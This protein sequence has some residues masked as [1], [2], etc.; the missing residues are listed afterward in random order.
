VPGVAA[1]G[2]RLGMRREHLADGVAGQQRRFTGVERRGAGVEH[3]V[4]A[5]VEFAS[6]DHV[7]QRRMVVPIGG[8]DLELHLVARRHCAVA[9]VVADEQH[10]LAASH[11][12]PA[13][14][15]IAVTAHDRIDHLAVDSADRGA[16]NRQPARHRAG[17]VNEPPGLSQ[18][19]QFSGALDEAQQADEIGGVNQFAEAGKGGID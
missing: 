11:G 4:V 19:G 1:L 17:L 13:S 3:V 5:R 6:Q 18:I 16:R 10:L 7:H 2:Q 15:G 9:R 12:P 8:G 14:A